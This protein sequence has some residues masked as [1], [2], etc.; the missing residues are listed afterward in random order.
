MFRGRARTLKRLLKH[1]TAE[2]RTKLTFTSAPLETRNLAISSFPLST[3]MWIALLPPAWMGPLAS[4]PC[5][6]TCLQSKAWKPKIPALSLALA[7]SWDSHASRQI[8]IFSRKNAFL[9]VLPAAWIAIW[10]P[11]GRHFV[12]PAPAGSSWR[13]CWSLHKKRACQ[14]RQYSARDH[15]VRLAGSHVIRRKIFGTSQKKLDSARKYCFV[16]E[17]IDLRVR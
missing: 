13:C 3:A 17:V 15:S 14:A 4:V 10:Q 8:A 5:K 7:R 1:C 16:V 9:V 2:R 12:L 6:W 11:A